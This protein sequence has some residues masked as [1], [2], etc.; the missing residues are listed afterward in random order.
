MTGNCALDEQGSVQSIHCSVT[1]FYNIQYPLW[2]IQINHRWFNLKIQPE[3][4]L[5]KA[6][7]QWTVNKEEKRSELS[8][9]FFQVNRVMLKFW[10]EA[11]LN[12]VGSDCVLDISRSILFLH[13]LSEKKV[14][15]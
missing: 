14:T 5:N 12:L 15:G 13:V 8:H 10:V 7:S 1:P 2:L 9:A 4:G 3:T 6:K 11:K